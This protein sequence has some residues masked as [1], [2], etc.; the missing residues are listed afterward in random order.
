LKWLYLTHSYPTWDEWAVPYDDMLQRIQ[1]PHGYNPQSSTWGLALQADYV[2]WGYAKAHADEYDGAFIEICNFSS[3]KG[4]PIGLMQSKLCRATNPNIVLVGTW[5]SWDGRPK[6]LMA[7]Y[8]RVKQRSWQGEMVNLMDLLIATSNKWESHH[9]GCDMMWNVIF[10][11]DKFVNF[12]APFDMDGLKQFIV[13]YDKREH[14]FISA[15]PVNYYETS[16]RT[17]EV[18]GPSLPTGWKAGL[19]HINKRAV[20]HPFYKLGTLSWW[21][22]VKWVAKSYLGVFNAVNGGLASVAGLGA[23][24]KTPFVGSTTAD[25]VVECFPDL[26]KPAN[27][28]NG[29]IALVRQ[30]VNDERF[31]REV[32]DKGYQ[33]CQDQYSFKGANHILHDELQRRNKP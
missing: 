14:H 28:I 8:G 33:I 30:L 25:Y 1:Y 24:L 32:T 16:P 21:D 4:D 22:Y 12:L 3:A 29:Q 9:S 19:T 18:V 27:D 26:V 2:S 20:P 10:K 7:K 23:V 15:S 17:A 6:E 13:P 31:W 5:D 11:T